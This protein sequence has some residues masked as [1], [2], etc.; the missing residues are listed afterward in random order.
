MFNGIRFKSTLTLAL[1]P[2]TGRG[3]FQDRKIIYPLGKC[4]DCVGRLRNEEIAIWKVQSFPL[5]MRERAG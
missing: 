2:T 5:H 1:S 4:P 3:N